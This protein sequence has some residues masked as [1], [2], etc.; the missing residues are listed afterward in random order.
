MEAKKYSHVRL[1]HTS[2]Y[3][4]Q[5][6]HWLAEHTLSR[7]LLF[8]LFPFYFCRDMQKVVFDK[9]IKFFG[10]WMQV[11]VFD[12]VQIFL[13]LQNNSQNF[14]LISDCQ[15]WLKLKNFKS[16]SFKLMH[17]S[18]LLITFSFQKRINWPFLQNFTFTQNLRT[19]WFL[20]YFPHCEKAISRWKDPRE[21]KLLLNVGFSSAWICITNFAIARLYFAEIYSFWLSD[22]IP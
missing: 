18:T 22:A 7:I 3:C 9:L 21:M 19:T 16:K 6:R 2:A 15:V 4:I 8:F 5:D 11:L 14:F 1:L 12:K 17:P 20:S 10:G 13:T